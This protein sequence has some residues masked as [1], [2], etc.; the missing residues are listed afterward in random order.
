MSGY[1]TLDELVDD[2][3]TKFC[4][5][6]SSA[7]PRSFTL[8]VIC[9]DENGLH[10]HCNDADLVDVLREAISHVEGQADIGGDRS[11]TRIMH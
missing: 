9:R 8:T 10:I 7:L 11:R 4:G 2:V 1:K 3:L 5:E 6:L